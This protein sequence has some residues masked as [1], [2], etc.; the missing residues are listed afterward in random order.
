[1]TTTRQRLNQT[2]LA[3]YMRRMAVCYPPPPPPQ[4]K[5]WRAPSVRSINVERGTGGGTYYSVYVEDTYFFPRS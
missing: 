1:M 5:P 3:L 4:S 2:A